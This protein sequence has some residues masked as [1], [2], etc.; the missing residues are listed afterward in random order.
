MTATVWV[1]GWQQACCGEPF[2]VG[3][4]VQWQVQEPD[5]G[6]AGRLFA[7]PPTI[8]HAEAHHGP[9]GLPVVSGRVRRIRTVDVR[10]ER[11]ERENTLHPVAG[12][13]RTAG[14][15]A[16]DG[17]EHRRQGFVGYLVDLDLD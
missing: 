8:D 4:R 7:T 9:E 6:F 5:L 13:A 11:G 1:D 15:E 16:S 17:P 10:Y 3:T 12:S 2:A 14:V